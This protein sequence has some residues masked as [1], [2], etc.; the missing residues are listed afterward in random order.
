MPPVT[1][2][3]GD[4][5]RA[6]QYCRLHAAQWRLDP[7]KIVVA[8]GSAGAA[9]ALYLIAKASRPIPHPAE[10]RWSA[11]RPGCSRDGR[12]C[13]DEHRSATHP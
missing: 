10:S 13:R 4:A 8:G 5:R 2:V 12:R 3:L 7:D 11:F 1:A 9:S 6:L